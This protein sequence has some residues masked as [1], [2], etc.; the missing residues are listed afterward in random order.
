M[1]HPPLDDV[2]RHVGVATSYPATG[3]VPET[4]KRRILAALGVDPEA[5]LTGAPAPDRIVVPKGVSCFRPDWLTDQ[6]GWGLTCQLYELRSD[7]SWGIGDFRDLADLATIAG[8]AGADFLGINPLHALFMAAPELR[9]PFTPSNRSFLYPIYIAMDDLPCEA[10]A[11]AA[12]LDQLRAADLVDY[13][14]VARAKLKGLG[15]VFEKAP[16]G[17]GRFAETAFEAFCREGGLPLRRHALFEALSFEMTAQGYGVGWTTWPAPYQA[18]DSPEVAAFARDNTTALAFHLWLQWISSIQL[19][20]AR[21]A[22]REAG[23]RIGI[24]LDL[25]VGEAADGSAT[26]SAPDLALR[27]LTIGA[28]PDVFAQEGQ[29]WHLTA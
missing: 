2:C 7:R 11:D 24:Y 29:N 3:P 8:K 6:P 10:P 21:Q 12:L 26:W 14:Q 18:V 9:S 22:A 23:M 16:F 1:T 20:A 15:A 5:P 4:T 27:D 25:A 17:D 13:V 28:P 19:D